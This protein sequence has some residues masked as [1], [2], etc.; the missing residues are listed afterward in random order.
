MFIHI[1]WCIYFKI[2]YMFTV[3][4][5]HTYIEIAFTRISRHSSFSGG[6][7]PLPSVITTTTTTTYT[8][9]DLSNVFYTVVYTPV[10]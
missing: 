3:I 9:T 1:N 6:L 10:K 4:G 2:V 5:V 7:S 8:Y